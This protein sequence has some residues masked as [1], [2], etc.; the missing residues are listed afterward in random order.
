MFF[1]FRGGNSMKLFYLTSRPNDK[2]QAWCVVKYFVKD[3]NEKVIAAVAGPFQD[4]ESVEEFLTSY[5]AG[6][7]GPLGTMLWQKGDDFF[8]ITGLFHP[9]AQLDRWKKKAITKTRCS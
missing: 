4:Q 5:G 1:D 8:C 2:Q 7:L 3:G 6:R 9:R